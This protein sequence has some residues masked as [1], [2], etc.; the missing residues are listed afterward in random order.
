MSLFRN[1][2]GRRS[3]GFN[4]FARFSRPSFPHNVNRRQG[5]MALGALTALAAPFI[6][7]KL[8]A[9]RAA[10]AGY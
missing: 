5:G 10:A 9:R 8:R 6:V 4:P 2:F 3:R 1:L 7:R